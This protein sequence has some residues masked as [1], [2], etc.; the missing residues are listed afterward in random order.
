V[1]VRGGIV[2]A[3]YRGRPDLTG[4]TVD[5]EGWLHS[6][7]VG[8]IDEDG[9]LWIVDRK[10]ELIIN[11]AGKN[12]SPANIEAQLKAAGPLIGQAMAVGDG[13]P[14][15][16]ALIVLDPDGAAGLDPGDPEVLA[17][18]QAEVD[19]A[20][21]HLSRVEQIKAFTVLDGDWTPG[22]EELTPTMKLRRKPI[23][24]RYAQEIDALY[25]R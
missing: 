2:M 8:R 12:M 9:F 13:R 17:R 4:E 24:A 3:G 11:A 15:N 7:D 6:G 10:K 14:Y 25:A 22:G 20:N 19:A 16:V 21:A 5:R 23:A 1:L 18:V